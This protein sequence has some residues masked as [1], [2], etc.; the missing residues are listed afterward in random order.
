[1]RHRSFIFLAVFLAALIF[2]AVAVYAYDSSRDDEIA[3]GV[4]VAG[5]DVGG[6]TAAQA[7][8]VVQDQVAG[9]LEKP[10]AVVYKGK[11]FSLSPQD[12]GLHADVGG[13]VDE[14]LA[15]SRDGSIVSRVARDMTGGEEDAQVPARVAYSKAAVA[16]LVE[17]V[18]KSVDQ[19]AKDASLS[20]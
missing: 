16:K 14:A 11:R 7:R 4:T 2:G 19:P 12:A 18:Q 10:V 9:P 8:R 13:M 17:R 20:F 5:V 3:K 1:M 6:M 15:K